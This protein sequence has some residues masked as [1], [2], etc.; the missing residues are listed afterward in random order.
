MGLSAANVAT[1][2]EGALHTGPAA[3]SRSDLI[4]RS[5][6]TGANIHESWYTLPPGRTLRTGSCMYDNGEP[7]NDFG[8]PASQISSPAGVWPEILAGA[9]DDFTLSGGAPGTDCHITTIRT[10][11]QFFNPGFETATPRTTFEGVHVTVYHNIVGPNV[12]SGAPTIASGQSGTYLV[13]RFIQASSLQNEVLVGEC[14]NAYQVDIPVDITVAYGVTYWLSIVPTFL[15]P[16]QSAWPFSVMNQGV[17]AKQGFQV[18]PSPPAIS[19]WTTIQGNIQDPG[20]TGAPAADTSFDLAFMLMGD[21]TSTVI[22]ACCDD[23]APLSC[24][25]GV[26]Q[27]NCQNTTQRFSPNTLCANMNPPC[28]TTSAG[29]CCL[30]DGVCQFLNPTD[31]QNTGGAWQAGNCTSSPCTP[32]N[33]LCTNAILVSNGTTV[34]STVGAITDGPADTPSAPC[35]NINQDVWFK[36]TSS[37]TGTVT[38]SLCGGTDYDSALAA[39]QTWNCLPALGLR[40]ACHNDFC[41]DDGQ[42]SFPATLNGQFLIRVGGAAL[43]TGTGSMLITCVPNGS[44]ACCMPDRT[45]QVLTQ[46]QCQ[47][48]GGM[49]T[50]GQ[51]CSDLTCPPPVNDLCANAILMT[52]DTI[53]I[54]NRGAD[55]DGPDETPTCSTMN[56]DIWYQVNADCDGLLV[57][58][59]CEGTNFDA[60]LAIYDGCVCAPSLGNRLGCN[61]DGCG[62]PGGPAK[63]SIPATNGQC[64][65]IRV[66]GNGSAQGTGTLRVDCVPTGQGACCHAN[67]MCEVTLPANC[68]A[69][70]DRFTPDDLCSPIT[71]AAPV[72]DLC[73]NAIL[74]S[75]NGTF[76]YDSRGAATDGP[77]DSPGPPC[78]NVNQDVWYQYIAI[79]DGQLSASLCTGTTYNAAMAIYD[80]CTCPPS[81]GAM[82]ACDNDSCGPGG[83]PVVTIPVTMGQCYLIRVGGEGAESGAGQLM[84]NCQPN[85][86]PGD[87]C[88]GDANNDCSVDLNDITGFVDV[89]LGNITPLPTGLC[90]TDTTNDGVLDG[91]DIQPFIGSLIN[92]N[93][94]GCCRGDMNGDGLLDGRDVQGLVDAMLLPALPCTSTYRAAD[95]NADD[96]VD[97]ADV[98]VLVNKLINGDVCP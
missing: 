77:L 55:T 95:I 23:S 11:F 51:P 30:S 12:P 92:A 28:G 27:L 10:A 53:L 87:I 65:L 73:A 70:D 90:R 18:P 42:I 19:F 16:P 6:R 4:I 5:T 36:Y 78:T 39:Y 79:C 9:A 85:Q 63:V 68:V 97:F 59:L 60:T 17:A 2:D 46:S 71:C 22:G 81:L 57:V 89:L 58:S 14:I 1:A 44:G 31:C 26:N 76:P 64:Y 21:E 93:S 50:G 29:A 24:M 7:L 35:T 48:A 8:F 38:V 49:Y 96:L 88:V 86:G 45:C 40:V 15:A 34:F 20:C 32:A 3:R 37:C 74:M 54:D 69:P 61:D 43:A 82:L 84:L 66:G 67:L 47:T 56:Q 13:S 62:S 52:S 98:D 75:S 33:G 25:D 83:P 41:G 72:N 91:R 80:G 94:C